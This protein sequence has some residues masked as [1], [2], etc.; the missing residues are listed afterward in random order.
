[1]GAYSP[2]RNKSPDVK[3]GNAKKL[4]KFLTEIMETRLCKYKLTKALIS[5]QGDITD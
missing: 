2:E 3:Y 4:S 5:R 1:V